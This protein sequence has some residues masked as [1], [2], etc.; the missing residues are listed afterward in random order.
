MGQKFQKPPP[1]RRCCSGW[2]RLTTGGREKERTDG[3]SLGPPVGPFT[4]RSVLICWSLFLTDGSSNDE[5]ADDDEDDSGGPP[6]VSGGRRQD[7][8]VRDLVRQI[9]PVQESRIRLCSVTVHLGFVS[10]QQTVKE[11]LRF[12]FRFGSRVTRQI[13]KWCG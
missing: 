8:A 6:L 1:Q 10:G 3:R 5:D 2:C 9:S 7:V 4:R 13:L 11:K 12:R